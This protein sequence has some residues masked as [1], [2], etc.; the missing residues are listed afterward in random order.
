MILEYILIIITIT[1]TITIKI[2][3]HYAKIMIFMYVIYYFN[4]F[5]TLRPAL[6]RNKF[7]CI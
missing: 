5:K 4:I 7:D 6:Q 2:N 1:I 3:I